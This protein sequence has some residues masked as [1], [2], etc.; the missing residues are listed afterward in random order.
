MITP[1]ENIM[2]AAIEQAKQSHLRGEYAVGAAIVL[3]NEIIAEA[4]VTL[5]KEQDPTCH[6]EINAI[7]AACK[8]L[9]TRKLKECILYT[10]H[11]PCAMCATASVWAHM[12]G[13]VFGL[14]VED[15]NDYRRK[16]NQRLVTE[17]SVHTVAAQGD[18][19]LEIVGPFMREE[20]LSLLSL[21]IKE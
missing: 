8:V 2:K 17:I 5:L 11:E 15:M 3:N 12:K 18:P 4:G 7:R 21:G 6:A 13:I 16:N 10:T 1:E 19:K 20:C 9:G 14:T